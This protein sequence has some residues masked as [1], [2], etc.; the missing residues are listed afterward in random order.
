[1][2]LK[3]LPYEKTYHFKGLYEKQWWN[4]EITHSNLINTQVYTNFANKIIKYGE[5]VNGQIE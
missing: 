4:Q 1:M 2:Y 5:A 3:K